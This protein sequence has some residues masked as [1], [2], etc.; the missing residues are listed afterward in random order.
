MNGCCFCIVS[1]AYHSSYFGDG[2]GPIIYSDVDCGGWEKSISECSKNSFLQFSCL[3]SS[4]AG[5]LCGY[6]EEVSN[7]FLTCC[8]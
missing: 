7:N 3:R 6:G 5:I 4:V 8:S 2:S 1:I